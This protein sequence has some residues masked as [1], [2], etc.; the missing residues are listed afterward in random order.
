[1]DL[2]FN[3]AGISLIE[4]M[5]VVAMVSILALVSSLFFKTQTE[6]SVLLSK[7]LEFRSQAERAVDKFTWELK[8]ADRESVEIYD[9]TGSSV[10]VTQGIELHF[11][12]NSSLTGGILAVE[13]IYDDIS[14]DLY[15]VSG[16]ASKRLIDRIQAQVDINT[17]ELYVFSKMNDPEQPFIESVAIEFGPYNRPPIPDGDERETISTI[18]TPRN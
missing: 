10:G 18:V 3:D 9:V 12:Y 14:H 13:Y 11:E 16:S 5:I 2:G 8:Q 6:A 4:I 17:G 7:K 15:R 1:M